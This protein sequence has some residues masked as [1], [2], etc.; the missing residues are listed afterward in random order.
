[1]GLVRL[2]WFFWAILIFNLVPHFKESTSLGS[3]ILRGVGGFFWNIS[4]FNS[5]DV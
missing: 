3:F 4:Y 5:F 1:V 2:F